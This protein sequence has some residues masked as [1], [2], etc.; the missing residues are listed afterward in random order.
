MINRELSIMC[1]AAISSVLIISAPT[2]LGTGGI[3]QLVSIG[4]RD[5]AVVVS[6]PNVYAAWTCNNHILFAKSNNGGKTF[7]NTVLLSTPHTNPKI[8]VINDNVSISASGN[9]VSILW[10]SNETG[11]INPVL[12][13][14]SDSGNTFSNILT[15]NSTPGGINKAAGSNMTGAAGNATGGSHVSSTHTTN[16]AAVRPNRL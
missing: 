4:C 15:L 5:D 7:G 8:H 14:S 10:N 9:T 2:V 13:T 6:G 16:P 11:M 12:R 1:A 3:I